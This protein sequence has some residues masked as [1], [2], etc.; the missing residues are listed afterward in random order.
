[1]NGLH[2]SLCFFPVRKY[3]SL[4]TP[5]KCKRQYIRRYSQS[6]LNELFFR[7]CGVHINGQST[8]QGYHL[9]QKWEVHLLIE[10]TQMATLP[11]RN[12]DK[13]GI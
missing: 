11:A 3:L 8:E 2:L 5:L 12:T 4:I 9:L 10:T 13:T 1:M 6:K 7:S